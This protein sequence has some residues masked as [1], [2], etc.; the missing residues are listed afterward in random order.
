MKEECEHVWYLYEDN[1]LIDLQCCKC[2]EKHKDD[3]I[4]KYVTSVSG[5]NAKLKSRITELEDMF[6]YELEDGTRLRIGDHFTVEGEY[7]FFSDGYENYNAEMIWWKEEGML[8]ASLY[9]ISDRVSGAG[10]GRGMHDIDIS[11]IRLREAKS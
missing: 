2:Q 10:C 1:G 9:P 8:Y 3:D 6:S 5:E 4:E 7:P 11:K